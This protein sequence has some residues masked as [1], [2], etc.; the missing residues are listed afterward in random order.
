MS[1]IAEHVFENVMYS[2]DPTI[3]RLMDEYRD[4]IEEKERINRYVHRKLEQVAYRQQEINNCPKP[5]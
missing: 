2:D 1:H 5:R 3:K 4:L